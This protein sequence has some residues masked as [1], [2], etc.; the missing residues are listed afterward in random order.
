MRFQRHAGLPVTVMPSSEKHFASSCGLRRRASLQGACIAFRLHTGGTS[1]LFIKF[2]LI[3]W[4]I[5]CHCVLVIVFL[6]LSLFP[7]CV[8]LPPLWRCGG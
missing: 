5:L 2:N 1:T 7:S 8:F 6:V 3:S 4:M